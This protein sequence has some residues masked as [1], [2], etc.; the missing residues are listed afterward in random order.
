MVAFFPWFTIEVPRTFG[1]FKLLPHQIGVPSPYSIP[2]ALDFVFG[3]YRRSQ[4]QPVKRLCVVQM[5]AK[6][7]DAD[8]SDA[9]REDLF[10]FAECLATAA[11]AKRQFFTHHYTNRDTFAL[12]LQ[13]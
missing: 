11:L 7:V 10:A 6:P 3:R 13:S 9:E 8:L 5:G 1:R 12:V 2:T 4:S